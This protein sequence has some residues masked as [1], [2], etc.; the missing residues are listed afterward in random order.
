ASPSPAKVL[1]L[2]TMVANGSG[3]MGNSWLPLASWG[4]PEAGAVVVRGNMIEDHHFVEIGTW[5]N[6]GSVVGTPVLALV[7]LGC[8]MGGV[9]VALPPPE[10]ARPVWLAL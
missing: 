1:A 7:T 5:L 10:G 6:R 2:F 8:T 4:T 3:N 9:L